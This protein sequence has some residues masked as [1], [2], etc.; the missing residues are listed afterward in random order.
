MHKV[1]MFAATE[2]EYRIE[3]AVI[4]RIV[5]SRSVT[6]SGVFDYQIANSIFRSRLVLETPSI[7]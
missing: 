3:L 4:R 6:Y 1:I 5:V 7:L 2:I